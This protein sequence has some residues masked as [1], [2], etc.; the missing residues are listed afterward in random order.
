MA[1][2][3][4]YALVT[5][6]GKGGIGEALVIEYAR[7]GL[8]AIATVL[9]GESSQHLIDADI[10]FFTL[11]VT[12]ESSILDLKKNLQ[13]LTNGQLD[14]LVNNASQH[15]TLGIIAGYTMTAV[16]TDVASVQRMFEV[17]VFGPMRMVH[18]L[19][20]MLINA[21]GIIVNIGSIGGVVPYAYGGTKPNLPLAGWPAMECLN[22]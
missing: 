19:H 3:E 8:K 18:H 15:L 5:G 14:I 16:D 4:K 1:G 22:L 2:R 7:R 10:T 20:D 21:S 13:L 11:D 12:V 17:N 9:P 6:C